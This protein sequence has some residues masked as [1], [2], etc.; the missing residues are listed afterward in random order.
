MGYYT[1]RTAIVAFSCLAL[2][3]CDRGYGFKPVDASGSP[4]ESHTQN[5]GGV[6]YSMSSFQELSGSTSSIGQL[7][8]ENDSAEP[9]TVLGC[10]LRAGSS[11]IEAV[12]DN[13]K[14]AE[15]ARTISQKSSGMV[16]L[17]L[18]Y[19][20]HANTVFDEKQTISWH[21]KVRHGSREVELTFEMTSHK[22]R[23]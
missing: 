9:V 23:E 13:Q 18:N 20:D 4:V 22:G 8:I 1:M 2:C 17:L 7:N 12:I 3:G 14:S 10:T 16:M 21:W 6:K 5:I 11:I 15:R 19:S